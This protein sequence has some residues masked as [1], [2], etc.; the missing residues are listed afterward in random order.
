MMAG[1]PVSRYGSTGLSR[2]R[3]DYIYEIVR[4]RDLRR[5]IGSVEVLDGTSTKDQPLQ[6]AS[7]S[8][9]RDPR[10]SE[11]NR[12]RGRHSDAQRR[13]GDLGHLA[14][15]RFG[16]RCGIGEL[17]LGSWTH[18]SSLRRRIERAVQKATRGDPAV[19]G[20]LDPYGLGR[21]H[22]THQRGQRE[23]ARGTSR[24]SVC[25]GKGYLELREE[26]N[27]ACRHIARPVRPAGPR[28]PEIRSY[29]GGGRFPH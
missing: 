26:L 13:R 9:D 22:S 11:G 17:P 3:Q 23:V 15:R 7:F 6:G 28:F 20:R 5:R 25:S 29:R 1:P 4:G 10:T 27:R 8:R 18:R 12:V 16:I 24:W 19:H 21:V 14:F 2:G